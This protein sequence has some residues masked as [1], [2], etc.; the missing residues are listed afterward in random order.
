MDFK[1]IYMDRCIQLARNGILTTAPNPMVGAVIVWHD[2][3]IGEGYHIRC[4]EGH[5]EVNAIASVKRKELLPESTLYVSLEPCAHYGK[6][7]PC[8]DLIVE[9]KIPRVVIG[10]KDPFAKVAGRGIQ[11]LLDA[12]IEVVVGVKEKECLALNKHFLTFHQYKRPFITLKW[13]ESADRFL[14]A[15][16]TDPQQGAYRFSTPETLTLVHKRRAEHQ[17]ILVGGATAVKDNP[18]LNVRLWGG[19]SPLRL[20]W[21]TCGSLPADLK[22]LHNTDAPTRI[23]T[24]NP[25]LKLHADQKHLS[26]CLLHA[27]ED[28]LT[29][30]LNDLHQMNILSLLVEG[31]AE[32]LHRFIRRDLWD[33]IYVEQAPVYLGKGVQAPD[34]PENRERKVREYYGRP[35]ICLEQNLGCTKDSF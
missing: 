16:R 3:I 20:V 5:A 15:E 19:R 9:K 13:A 7:P 2:Q 17:A 31:G 12:G 35:I 26:V 4:G 32:T 33:E 14:D 25:D 6:T 22:L 1:E 29:Q 34:L 30:I 11:K 28:P 24:T 21:D 27:E 23:Y 10:C 18:T 8:A